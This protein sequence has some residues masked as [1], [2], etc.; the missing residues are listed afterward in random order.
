MSP[1]RLETPWFTASALSSMGQSALSG[2][3]DI[4]L[5]WLASPRSNRQGVVSLQEEVNLASNNRE[6]FHSCDMKLN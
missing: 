1:S 3:K 4:S 5:M 6:V 2:L